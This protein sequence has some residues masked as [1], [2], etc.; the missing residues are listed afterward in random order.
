[1]PNFQQDKLKASEW[2]QSMLALPNFY[3]LDGET[4]GLKGD[5]RICQLAIV[6]KSGII[7]VDTLV[8][9]QIAIPAE[10]TG[11]HGITD[12]MVASAPTL[13]QILTPELQDKLF[14]NPLVIYN[15]DYDLGV[16]RNHMKMIGS[17]FLTPPSVHC[18]MKKYSAFVGSWNDYHKSYTFQKLPAVNKDLQHTALGDCLSTLALIKQ[19]AAFAEYQTV[20]DIPF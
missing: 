10:A 12:D 20:D 11:I 8:N 1:M 18:A 7:L 4:T 2:S 15:A 9:P 14:H 13:D 5:V 17:D 3:I 6:N 19:M 16:L